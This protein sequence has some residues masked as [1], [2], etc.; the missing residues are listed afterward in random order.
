MVILAT[1]A[2]SLMIGN[3]WLAPLLLRAGWGTAAPAAT[4]LTRCWC[5]NARHPRHRAA[6]LGVFARRGRERCLADIGA[7]VVFRPGT[8]AP[9]VLAAIYRPALGARAVGAGIGAGVAV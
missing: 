9:A 6:G 2:L 3:H 4:C 7:I 5:S 8:L 1:L